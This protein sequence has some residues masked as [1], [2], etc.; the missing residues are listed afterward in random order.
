MY[1][2]PSCYEMMHVDVEGSMTG[3]DGLAYCLICAGRL[4][5]SNP[6]PDILSE[7]IAWQIAKD[8]GADRIT[9]R[10]RAEARQIA[11][12]SFR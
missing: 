8:G 4:G 6:N 7:S 1:R 12:G 11:I 5:F 9:S 10:I 3:P 2:C